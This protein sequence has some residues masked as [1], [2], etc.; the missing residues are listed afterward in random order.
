[1]LLRYATRYF[2]TPLF[3][4]SHPHPRL[5][6]S[7]TVFSTR[8]VTSAAKSYRLKSSKSH[9]QLPTALPKRVDKEAERLRLVQLLLEREAKLNPPPP[10]TPLEAML[11]GL[12]GTAPMAEGSDD[13][14]AAD[15]EQAAA[16]GAKP[17]ATTKMSKEASMALLPPPPATDAMLASQV[18]RFQAD[19]FRI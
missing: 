4:M 16:K 3:S 19:F 7:L 14:A 12:E 18:G 1:M 8:R 9:A 2:C 15:Q 6:T 5:P 17:Q 11:L 13:V 10:R